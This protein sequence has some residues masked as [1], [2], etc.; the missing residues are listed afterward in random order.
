MEKNEAGKKMQVDLITAAV[1]QYTIN[2][3]QLN[4]RY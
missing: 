3:Q 4:V 2:A 1:N